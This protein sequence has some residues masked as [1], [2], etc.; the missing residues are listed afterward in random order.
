VTAI[1]FLDAAPP[2]LIEAY[3]RAEDLGAALIDDRVRRQSIAMLGRLISDTRMIDVWPQLFELSRK[4]SRSTN[5]GMGI[6]S[7]AQNALVLLEAP[8]RSKGQEALLF[9]EISNLIGELIRRIDEAGVFGPCEVEEFMTDDELYDFSSLT[10]TRVQ[11]PPDEMGLIPDFISDGFVKTRVK[12]WGII[13]SLPELLRRFQAT[14]RQRAASTLWKQPGADSAGNNV[15]ALCISAHVYDQYE[16][17]LDDLV[18]VF[19]TVALNLGQDPKIKDDDRKSNDEINGTLVQQLRMTRK[20]ST[21]K[22]V[23]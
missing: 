2:E 5:Y 13:P 11:S 15:F 8:R 21:P 23:D 4:H 3:Q 12:T 22:S 10:H 14:S 1:R 17:Y 18:G 7:A 19:T 20:S 16:A 9:S 6:F